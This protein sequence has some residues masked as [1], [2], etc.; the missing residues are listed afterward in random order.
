MIM[1]SIAKPEEIL[2]L[3]NAKKKVVLKNEE[4]RYSEAHENKRKKN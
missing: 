1:K 2:E 4:E 3:E